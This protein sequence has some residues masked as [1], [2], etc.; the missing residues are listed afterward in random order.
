M[1]R[2]LKDLTGLRF[3]T[4]LVLRRSENDRVYETAT[5]PR[6]QVYWVVHC[7]ACNSQ[8]EVQGNTLKRGVKCP[9]QRKKN[10]RRMKKDTQI[11]E[12]SSRAICAEVSKALAGNVP[13]LVYDR[14]LRL[15]LE[16]NRR[17]K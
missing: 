1:P 17:A 3:D 5:G 7:E 14:I 16:L 10:A 9:C 4:Q 8:R 6:S 2:K 12:M 15:I 13:P 11:Q